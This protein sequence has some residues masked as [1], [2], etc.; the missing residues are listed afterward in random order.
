MSKPRAYRPSQ[1]NSNSV[2]T[3]PDS[4][5]SETSTGAQGQPAMSEGASDASSKT[6]N[7]VEQ[8]AATKPVKPKRERRVYYMDA[9]QH[10]RAEAAFAFTA[11]HTKLRS[12]TAFV[13]SAIQ[14]KTR[15]LEAK[16]NDARPFTDL[17]D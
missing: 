17:E 2:I 9:D 10:A 12:W 8:P 4:G 7:S 13:E 15:A 16:Y 14:E 3:P 5:V 11:G 1:L 6:N